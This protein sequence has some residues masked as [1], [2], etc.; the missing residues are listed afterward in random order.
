MLKRIICLF[1]VLGNIISFAAVVSDND[2]STF[3]T[4][5]E[6]EALKKDFNEQIDQYNIS[7]DTKI[8]GAIAAYLAGIKLANVEY[9]NHSYFD[10][11]V[12]GEDLMWYGGTSGAN[13]SMNDAFYLPNNIVANM[14]VWRYWPE[15]S[16]DTRPWYGY[17]NYDGKGYWVNGSGDSGSSTGIGYTKT[18]TKNYQSYLICDTNDN[19][20]YNGRAATNVRMTILNWNDS[21]AAD[22]VSPIYNYDKWGGQD[23]WSSRAARWVILRAETEITN[24]YTLALCPM[25]TTQYNRVNYGANRWDRFK[26]AVAN[27]RDMLEWTLTSKSDNYTGSESLPTLYCIEAIYYPE[28]RT[29]STKKTLNE[30]GYADL[31]K[32]SSYNEAIKYG[33]YLTTTTKNAEITLNLTVDKAGTIYIRTA[34]NKG[35][36]SASTEVTR[37]SVASGANTITIAEVKKDSN[38][39]IIYAPSGTDVGTISSLTIKATDIE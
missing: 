23:L 35:N 22:M 12:N 28:G 38:I 8:D 27:M 39:F 19:I 31:I 21:F 2:G 24:N 33:V 18:S 36:A 10:Y 15:K 16:T 20:L 3:T 26:T 6:L 32:V 17:R 9:L 29:N 37:K 34:D 4:K 14:K 1:I 11:K 13:R 30:Y 5:A 7:I 25:S